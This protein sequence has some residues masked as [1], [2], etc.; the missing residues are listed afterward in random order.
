MMFCTLPGIGRPF[1]A[2]CSSSANGCQ[3]FGSRITVPDSDISNGSL[4]GV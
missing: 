3:R 1:W 4:A 2:I